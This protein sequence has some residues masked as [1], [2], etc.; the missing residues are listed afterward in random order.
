AFFSAKHLDRTSQDSNG[1][2]ANQSRQTPARDG[3]SGKRSS[4]YGAPSIATR[5]KRRSAYRG[6][7]GHSASLAPTGLPAPKRPSKAPPSNASVRMASGLPL[8]TTSIRQIRSITLH[9][10][11]RKRTSKAIFA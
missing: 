8:E 4:A 6:D 7:S 11:L 5:A 3:S 9:L 1:L 10:R 2:G